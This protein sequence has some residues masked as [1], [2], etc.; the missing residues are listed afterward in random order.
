[1]VS[2]FFAGYLKKLGVTEV[3]DTN[4]ARSI[5][6]IESAK[7]LHHKIQ[8]GDSKNFPVLSSA[9]PGEFLSHKKLLL[10]TKF[11]FNNILISITF[12]SLNNLI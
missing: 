5:S 12:I 6:L 2:K 3:W 8:S 7:E 11:F 9:C 1:M 10:L 4:I